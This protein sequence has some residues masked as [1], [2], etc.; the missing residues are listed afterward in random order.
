MEIEIKVTK[1]EKVNIKYLLVLAKPRYWEDTSVNGVED[2]EGELIPCRDGELWKPRINVDNGN[3]INWEKGKTASVHY[4]VCDAGDYFLQDEN[5]I[6]V[7]SIV[8]DYVP[9]LL[10]PDENGYGDYIIMDID[11]NG[12]INNWVTEI[13]DFLPN[14]ED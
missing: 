8:D 1:K 3:I 12:H 11:E 4:K 13:S 5:N 10:C 2:T 7:L 9:S 14:D 6:T